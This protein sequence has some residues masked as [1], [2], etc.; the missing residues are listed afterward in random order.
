MQDNKRGIFESGP[1]CY[2]VRIAQEI[3]TDH[4]GVAPAPH[5]SPEEKKAYR[6]WS[7]WDRGSLATIQD[8]Y[9]CQ[10]LVTRPC[11]LTTASGQGGF[12]ECGHSRGVRGVELGTVGVWMQVSE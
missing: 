5:A 4:V 6:A 12:P 3:N 9:S 10:E 2:P 8:W 1:W 7:A 11:P